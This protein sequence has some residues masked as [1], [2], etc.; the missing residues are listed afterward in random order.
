MQ[1]AD[2]LSDAKHHGFGNEYDKPKNVLPNAAKA[3][4]TSIIFIIPSL[5]YFYLYGGV[6]IV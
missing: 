4:I 2:R 5:P 6:D 3:F 1:A